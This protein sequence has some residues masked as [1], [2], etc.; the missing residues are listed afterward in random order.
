MYVLYSTK[1][2]LQQAADAGVPL[3]DATYN[4]VLYS[5]AQ[6]GDGLG[7]YKAHSYTNQ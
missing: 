7:A 5:R 4:S 2:I 1:V 6:S 3:D